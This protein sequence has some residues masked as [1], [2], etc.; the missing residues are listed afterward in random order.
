MIIKLKYKLNIWLLQNKYL[1][2]SQDKQWCNKK[3]VWKQTLLEAARGFSKEIIKIPWNKQNS[4][5]VSYD[6]PRSTHNKL[7]HPSVEAGGNIKNN[8]KCFPSTEEGS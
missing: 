6:V 8:D 5:H 2:T 7:P 1:G 4:L 3:N